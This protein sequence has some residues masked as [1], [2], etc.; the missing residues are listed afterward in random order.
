MTLR[1][2]V[3][4]AVVAAILGAVP[5]G[6]VLIMQPGHAAVGTDVYLLFL[7]A[8]LLLAFVQATREAAPADPHAAFTRE[9]SRRPRPR[10]RLGELS[11]QEREVALSMDAAYDLHV[12]LRPTLRLIAGHR[13]AT[14]R[15]IDLDAHP[16]RARAALGDETW[17]LVRADRE[18]PA[19]RFARGL[20]VERLRAVVDSLERI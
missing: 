2:R 11:R 20:S 3:A 10:E 6:A 9:L 19:D 18:P 15:N 13:L 8:V 16:E 1:R 12:R 4:G 7:A 17:E 14:R 5:L